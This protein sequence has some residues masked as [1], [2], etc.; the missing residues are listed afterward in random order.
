[1][2][3]EL[4]LGDTDIR[5]QPTHISAIKN[6]KVVGCCC[7]EKHSVVL[8]SHIPIKAKDDSAFKPYFKIL[9]VCR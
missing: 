2:L 7:G 5:L 3:G 1:M 6:T 4:G 9:Q 8:T